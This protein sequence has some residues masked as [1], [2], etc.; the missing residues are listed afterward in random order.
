[1]LPG[2]LSCHLRPCAA[3]ANGCFQLT[4]IPLTLL[5][6]PVLIAQGYLQ[7]LLTPYEVRVQATRL[8]FDC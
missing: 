1:M 2:A 3:A 4:A 8:L 6:A 7:L 5:T